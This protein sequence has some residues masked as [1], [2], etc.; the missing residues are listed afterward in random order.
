MRRNARLIMPHSSFSFGTELNK[1][2][3]GFNSCEHCCTE[4]PICECCFRP[5]T[6]EY[7]P[8]TTSFWRPMMSI[9]DFTRSAA[10][11]ALQVELGKEH[12][13]DSHELLRGSMVSVSQLSDPNTE[14]SAAQEIRVTKNLLKLSKAKPLLGLHLGQRYKP[15][16]YGMW[17]FGL[18]SCATLGDAMR[19]AMRF[20]PLTFTFSTIRYHDDGKLIHLQFDETTFDEE[21][22]RFL[23]HR[24][25]AA[26]LAL[27]KSILGDSF[28]LH[29]VTF[30]HNL[31]QITHKAEFGKVFGVAP[32]F[33]A[34]T[35]SLVFENSYLAQK[36]PMAY[37]TAATMCDQ[38]CAE[39]LEK[40]RSK[41]GTTAVVNQ[42]LGMNLYQIPKLEDMAN[43]L[44]TSERT[45]KRML[46]NENTSFRQLV[47]DFQ[48]SEAMDYLTN[49]DFSIADI[50]QRLG[51]SDAS[52]FSQ[53]FK[54]WTGVAPLHYKN[55]RSA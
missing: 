54:R 51:F 14:V 55:Q 7:R 27:F 22:K 30:R 4:T 34:D 26:G 37:P 44:N 17:G 49:S 32:V 45:L 5:D 13:L 25:M 31:S 36:L 16:V 38:Y 20:L 43:L 50:A 2:H 39:L 42:Y 3:F 6:L 41:L 28:S 35:N 53:S 8:P 33:G 19:H 18:I 21:L 40:R 23:L 1:S 46:A 48:C 15:S 9:L 10:S 29:Q 12:G 52:S 47:K 24:D 11:I